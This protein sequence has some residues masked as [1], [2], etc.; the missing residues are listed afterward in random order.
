MAINDESYGTVAGVGAL[1]P[2]FAGSAQDFADT[3]RPTDTE[4]ETFINQVSS[5]LNSMLATAGFSIPV[6]EALVLPALTLFVEQEVAAIIEGIRGSGR[7]GPKASSKPTGGRF[8]VIYKDVEEFV[9]M[10]AIG[11][12]R[13]GASVADTEL[14]IGDFATNPLGRRDGYSEANSTI[15]YVDV[16]LYD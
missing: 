1:I 8:S 13:M 2:R 5:I 12:E 15:E 7:F 11:F 9:Q 6:D 10:N 16:D 4:V 14:E 3:E